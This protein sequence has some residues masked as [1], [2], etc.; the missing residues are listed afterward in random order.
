[1]RYNCNIFSIIYELYNV[2]TAKSNRVD[3]WDCVNC[4]LFVPE[5]I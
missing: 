1:M 5:T 2:S 3:T 4:I